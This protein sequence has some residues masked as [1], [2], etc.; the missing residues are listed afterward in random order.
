MQSIMKHNFA[1]VPAPTLARS[2]FDRSCGHKT[3]INADYIYPIFIDEGLPGDTLKLNPTVF[4]RMA[5]PIYPLMDNLF[6]DTFWFS[7]PYRLLW[8]N[9]HKFLGAQDSP[10]DSIDFTIPT[11]PSTATTGYAEL[12]IFDYMGIPPGIPDF[13]HSALPLRAYQLIWNEWF[14]DQN[15]QD[16]KDISNGD[17]PDDPANYALYKR[18]KRH[19]YFT[20][21]LPYPQKSD[22]QTTMPLGTS[23]DIILSGGTNNSN[24]GIRVATSGTIYGMD[25]DGTAGGAVLLN[26]TVNPTIGMIADL[27]NATAA[28]I[29]AIRLAVTTQQ[30]LERD[31]RGGTRINEIILSH[32]GVVTPDSRVQRPEYLGGSTDRV[33]INTVPQTSETATTPQGTLSAFGTFSTQSGG[34]NTSLTEHCLII[35]LVNVRADLTYQKGVEKLW[36]RST[37]YDFYWPEFANIG[38]Q[39]VL[40]QE[41]ELTNPAGGTNENV[42]GYQER[43]AE[44]RFKPS[45]I[46]G[47][48]RSTA[49]GSLD[50]WHLSEELSTPALNATFI[51]SNT[52]MA[53]VEAV[54]AEPD[55][56]VD[57]YFDYK[58]IRP[59]PTYGTP[60]LARF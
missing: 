1:N 10:G 41:I 22:T 30:F 44:Y 21:C 36:T 20:S 45:R 39:A 58:C 28:S 43:Y 19:D 16:S 51:Q 49:T 12:S 17:G 8:L 23:A 13:D 2:Q 56:I 25:T 42:F 50:P 34:F 37:R 59:M 60:G 5:T 55:F 18:G 9:W 46:S 31:A 54:P 33:S 4:A 40:Q 38:E 48:F 35:G 6:I 53:R 14:R 32:F 52:P 15:L 7:V 11:M 57:M 24:V 26:T 29:N 3:T 27:S 47:L